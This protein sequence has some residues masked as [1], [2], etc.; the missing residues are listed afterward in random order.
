ML[1]S[2]L[3]CY[4]NRVVITVWSLPCAI[5]RCDGSQRIG[6]IYIRSYT[7]PIPSHWLSAV[8]ALGRVVDQQALVHFQGA[9]LVTVVELCSTDLHSVL[10]SN[11][12]P[13]PTSVIKRLLHDLLKGF[14]PCTHTVCCSGSCFARMQP[15]CWG[16]NGCSVHVTACATCCSYYRSLCVRAL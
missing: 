4:L 13:L 10:Y 8:Q 1:D 7:P 16:S 14:M 11:D 9:H 12:F 5:T 6:Y 3:Y 15:V 2:H